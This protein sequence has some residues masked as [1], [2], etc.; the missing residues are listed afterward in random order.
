MALYRPG[1]L[2]NAISGKIAGV[3]FVA[4]TRQLAVRKLRTPSS[5]TSAAQ[6]NNRANVGR[7]IT[8]WNALTSNQ[9]N[10]WNTTAAQMTTQ[11]RLGLP[12]NISGREL[13]FRRNLRN[14]SFVGIAIQTTPP[15]QTTTS[16]PYQVALS[17]PMASQILVN[18]LGF[19]YG[20]GLQEFLWI[21][22]TFSGAPRNHFKNWVPALAPGTPIPG[23]TNLKPYFDALL[24]AP[25]IGE[26]IAVKVAARYQ[27]EWD[28][29]PTLGQL[30]VTL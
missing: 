11:N 14:L 6:I 18:V 13:F 4:G 2:T 23:N 30:I 1:P 16:A 17:N 9:R 15:T 5:N 10:A 28:S 25:G 3:D 27:D 22:R 20:A 29:T 8:A 24:G 21:C 26:R 7:V 19:P 12:K